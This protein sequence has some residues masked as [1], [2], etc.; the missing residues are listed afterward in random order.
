[1]LYFST[2]QNLEDGLQ[3]SNTIKGNRGKQEIIQ[4][5]KNRLVGVR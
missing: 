2:K 1:M 3:L 5:V 4:G